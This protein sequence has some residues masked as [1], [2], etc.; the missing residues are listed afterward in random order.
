VIIKRDERILDARYLSREGDAGTRWWSAMRGRNRLSVFNGSVV[1]SEVVLGGRPGQL[2]FSSSITPPGGTSPSVVV[3]GVAVIAP[4]INPSAVRI[5]ISNSPYT[6]YFAGGGLGYQQKN[7]DGEWILPIYPA[8]GPYVYLL[9]TNLDESWPV[10]GSFYPTFPRLMLSALNI[11]TG[12]GLRFNMEAAYVSASWGYYDNSLAV[13][14][15]AFYGAIAP[16][17]LELVAVPPC[18]TAPGYGTVEVL[19]WIP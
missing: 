6:G 3:G 19:E 11:G 14:I 18:Y 15:G 10:P 8:A 13:E 4:I 7:P 17:T 1:S 16:A 5:R 9:Y 12:T 2:V